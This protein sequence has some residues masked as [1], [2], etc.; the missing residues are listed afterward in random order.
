M[1][2]L[3][4]ASALASGIQPEHS[5][6]FEG[7]TIEVALDPGYFGEEEFTEDWRIYWM[8]GEG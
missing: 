5:Y 1:Q 2:L 7:E 8:A 4:I 3:L 6:I